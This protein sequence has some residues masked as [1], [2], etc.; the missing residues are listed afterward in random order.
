MTEFCI[1]KLLGLL[2]FLASIVL[3]N[4]NLKYK[5]V[6]EFYFFIMSVILHKSILFR[7]SHL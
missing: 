1:G 7:G 3:K 5:L 6:P 2:G 4:G